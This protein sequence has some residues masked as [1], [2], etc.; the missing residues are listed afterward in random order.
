MVVALPRINYFAISL[1]TQNFDEIVKIL[2]YIIRGFEI[3][4]NWS[5]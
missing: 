3:F 1:N 4:K 5:S 2:M